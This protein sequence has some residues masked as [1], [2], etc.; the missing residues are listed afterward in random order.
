MGPFLHEVCSWELGAIRFPSG[1]QAENLAPEI[2]GKQRTDTR[3]APPLH[4]D[5][6]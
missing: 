3:R 1:L 5:L 4:L 6:I 2:Q